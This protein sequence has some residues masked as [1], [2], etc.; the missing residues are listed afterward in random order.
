MQENLFYEKQADDLYY[1]N[2]H[3]ARNNTMKAHFHKNVEMLFVIKGTVKAIINGEEGILNNN[4]IAISNGCDI[5]YYLG[6]S[7]SE[8]YV[9]VFGNIF[10]YKKA[11][12]N[13]EQHFKNYL[14]HNDKT[15]K[16]FDLLKM[17]YKEKNP[18][19]N[20]KV[21]F[22]N[23][24]YG[25][26]TDIYSD[27][28]MKKNTSNNDFSNILFYISKNASQELRIEDIAKRFGYSKN[29]FSSLFNKYMGIHFR[30]YLNSIRLECVEEIINNN[31]NVSICDAVL[32]SGF[33]S[34]NTYYR[35]KK[36]K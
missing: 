25:L 10:R 22:I 15:Y 8:V 28:I 26:L 35:A 23:Y 12:E 17:F 31:P 3:Y 18:N 7:D 16:I 32:S 20:L 13:D 2:F 30:E 34:M 11:N 27:K 19:L 6:D 36:K 5:H 1:F 21:G 24:L 29:H 33:N 4:D 9:L 14:Y